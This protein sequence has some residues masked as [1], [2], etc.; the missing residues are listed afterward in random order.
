MAGA[1]QI[2]GDP[3]TPLAGAAMLFEQLFARVVPPVEVARNLLLNLGADRARALRTALL[4]AGRPASTL[5]FAADV[6]LTV[7]R[8]PAAARQLLREALAEAGLTDTSSIDLRVRLAAAEAE[9]GDLLPAAETADGVLRARPDDEA[10]Q[11]LRSRCLAT[12]AAGLPAARGDECAARTRGLLDRV[13]DRA[14]MTLTQRTLLRYVRTRRDL[15]EL[16]T[17]NLDHW[18]DERALAPE[19]LAGWSQ[20]QQTPTVELAVEHAYVCAILDGKRNQLD[21]LV[22]DA[23]FDAT[24]DDVRRAADWST[25]DRWGLWQIGEL[26]DPTTTVVEY[27]TGARLAVDISPPQQARLTDR[28]ALIGHFVPVDGIWHSG[29]ELIELSRDRLPMLASEVLSFM[30]RVAEAEHREALADWA[31]ETRQLIQRGEYAP[32]A[33]PLSPSFMLD[34]VRRA[35]LAMVPALVGTLRRPAHG[36]PGQAEVAR[37]P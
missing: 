37:E 35:S 22:A 17:A 13:R 15:A 14:P 6:A 16:L 3:E 19:E 20:G 4:E 29:H 27:L 9:A 21:E 10:T 8:D 18:V 24:T 1:L 36:A 7:D 30:Q 31:R 23:T 34:D 12:L 5:A 11:L 32:G 2:L 26:G 33:V 25:Y 28:V